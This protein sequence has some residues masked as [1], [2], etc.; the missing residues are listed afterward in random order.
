MI[1]LEDQYEGLIYVSSS[2]WLLTTDL[3]A[4]LHHQQTDQWDN[5]PILLYLSIY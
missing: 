4:C 3:N 5:P 1:M 2:I